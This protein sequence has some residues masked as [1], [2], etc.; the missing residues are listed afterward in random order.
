MKHASIICLL[1]PTMLFSQ[2]NV[3]GVIASLNKE[4]LPLTNIVLLR[5][6]AGTITNEKG[7]FILSDLMTGDS[8]KISNI[9]FKSKLVA[10]KDLVN[11]DTIF[12]TENI[13]DLT[14]IEIK[15]LSGYKREMEL[16]FYRH[17]RV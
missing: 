9:A 12:L 3:I 1:F 11:N 7:V 15:N 2:I 13:K 5:K 14:A 17:K 16:G 4:P 10:A 6:N 8:I